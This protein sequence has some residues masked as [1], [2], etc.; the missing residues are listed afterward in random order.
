MEDS[1]NFARVVGVVAVLEDKDATSMLEILEPVLDEVVVTRTTSPRAMSPARL[2]A[3]ATEIFGED[4]VTVV[5]DPA[6][7]ARP[8]RRP[9]RRG[10]GRWRGAGHRIRHH[11]RRGADAARDGR[12]V[13]FVVLVL[14]AVVLFLLVT[15]YREGRLA[16]GGLSSGAR[17]RV[18]GLLAQGR[19][20][21]AVAVYREET[22]ASLA[23]AQ[24]VVG[25]WAAE[26]R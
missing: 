14:V 10:R 19:E 5:D 24:Q 2:G 25:R 21:D 15:R 18:E 17:I 8:G 22:G 26:R 12:A 16:R 11:R 7:R 20:A 13:K 6:R 4:R 3:L 9:G 1:F 23:Q